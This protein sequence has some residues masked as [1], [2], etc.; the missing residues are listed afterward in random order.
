MVGSASEA[1]QFTHVAENLD[2]DGVTEQPD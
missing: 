1:G 2:N